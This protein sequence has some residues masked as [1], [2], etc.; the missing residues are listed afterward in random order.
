MSK[1]E[2]SRTAKPS[3]FSEG[4]IDARWKRQQYI[5]IPERRGARI[6]LN[7]LRIITEQAH[8]YRS[9][10]DGQ[11]RHVHVSDTLHPGMTAKNVEGIV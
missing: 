1:P 2:L 3:I 4:P 7:K 5:R 6:G 9:G 11:L 10:A 8:Q